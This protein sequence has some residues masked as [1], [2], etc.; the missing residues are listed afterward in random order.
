MEK[1]LFNSIFI[2]IMLSMFIPSLS[3]MSNT[4]NIVDTKYQTEEIGFAIDSLISDALSDQT[5]INTCSI[6]ST[7]DYDN[8]IFA[9]LAEFE[10]K[11]L[12]YSSVSCEY[13]NLVSNINASRYFGSIDVLCTSSNDLITINLKK[14]VY[15]DKKI[16]A[17]N[18]VNCNVK[19]EDYLDGR[20]LQVDLNSS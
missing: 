3:L 4:Q 6:D 2:L 12:L 5:N 20:Y 19:I 8:L 15:F 9:Y 11:R 16:T 10:E 7:N 18:G 13:L 14:R 17:V 1:G